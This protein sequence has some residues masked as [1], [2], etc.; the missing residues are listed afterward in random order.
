MKTR[1]EI[2]RDYRKRNAEKIKAYNQTPER[3]AQ[4][5]ANQEKILKKDPDYFKNANKKWREENK[6]KDALRK[7]LYRAKK[8]GFDNIE[9]YQEHIKNKRELKKA[10]NKKRI[11]NEKKEKA[12]KRE[13]DKQER[14]IQRVNNIK[15]DIDDNGCHIIVS[16]TNKQKSGYHQFN[17]GVYVHR[18]VYFFNK[19]DIPKGKIILHTC[20][21]SDCINPNHLII[22]THKDNTQDMIEKGRNYNAGYQPKLTEKQ[23]KEIYLS[24]KSSYD[25]AEIYSVSDT[26]IRRIK[27]GTRCASITKT[28]H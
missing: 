3:K 15:Y 18:E 8:F 22:G 4:L 26:H 6:E 20:D 9:D 13:A 14:R 10:E 5:K 21:N 2:D 23:I 11:E 25:L 28:L 24:D 27:R 19:G 7:K 17:S 16:G 12:R 1:K